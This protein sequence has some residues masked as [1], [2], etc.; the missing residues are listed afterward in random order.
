MFQSEPIDLLREPD[1]E[2]KDGPYSN[3][4]CSP[5][6]YGKKVFYLP[7]S[8]NFYKYKKKQKQK[9]LGVVC[10]AAHTILIR[11]TTDTAKA[12]MEHFNLSHCFIYT[13]LLSITKP[14]QQKMSLHFI[15]L[16][17]FKLWCE[18]NTHTQVSEHLFQLLWRFTG[19]CM[20][21]TGGEVHV[22]R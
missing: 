4:K 6:P 18:P 7:D 20:D 11:T 3:E 15:L 5:G 9:D 17:L 21:E 13:W 1:T 19:G 2:C 10:G 14:N 12:E 16:K 8:R 22:K